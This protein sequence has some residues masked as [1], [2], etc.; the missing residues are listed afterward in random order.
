MAETFKDGASIL[1]LAQLARASK[2]TD[3]RDKIFGLLGLAS[4]GHD[5]V[6]DYL[7]NVQ[8]SYTNL[9]LQLIQ[10]QQQ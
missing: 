3:P 4:D 2:A 8:E 1:E 5:L 6:P 7:F 10:K 9:T